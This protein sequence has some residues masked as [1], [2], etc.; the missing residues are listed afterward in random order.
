MGYECVI[1]YT[2]LEIKPMRHCSTNCYSSAEP[3]YNISC[4]QVIAATLKMLS[5]P[6]LNAIEH[7]RTVLGSVA[8]QPYTL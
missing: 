4:I 7:Y 5:P 1:L 8:R 3:L 6:K 2:Y